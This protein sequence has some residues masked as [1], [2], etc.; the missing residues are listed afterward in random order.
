MSAEVDVDRIV[1]P[2]DLICPLSQPK[3]KPDGNHP[4]FHREAWFRAVDCVQEILHFKE[5]TD[6][7]KAFSQDAV[8]NDIAWNIDDV[9][10]HFDL[11]I[12]D[13]KTP[14]A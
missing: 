13:S 14:K 9:V 12:R 6:I 10:T 8:Q 3:F 7:R 11:R 5:D 4:G 1:R 2:V